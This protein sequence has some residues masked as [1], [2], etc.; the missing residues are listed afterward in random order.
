LSENTLTNKIRAKIKAD[1]IP[2]YLQQKL[3]TSYNLFDK[4]YKFS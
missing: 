3:Q 4:N 1:L 2:Q